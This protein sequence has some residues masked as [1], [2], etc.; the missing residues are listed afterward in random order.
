MPYWHDWDG[1]LP[2]QAI[3]PL[4][5]FLIFLALGIN[6]TWRRNGLTGITPLAMG[7]AYICF[8]AIFRNSGGR[9]ILPID[10]ISVLYYSVGLAFVSI[11]F[12]G[13]I[14]NRKVPQSFPAQ[15]G[16]S[17]PPNGSENLL[18]SYKF[19]GIILGFLLLGIAVPL[20]E[21]S[22]QQLY[23]E[24]R[25][26]E[27]LAELMD[28]QLLPEPMRMSLETFLSQ[29]GVAIAGRS[30]YPRF[31]PGATEDFTKK[32]QDLKPAPYHRLSF[33]IAGPTSANMV[34]PIAKKPLEFPNASNILVFACPD[35]KVLAV[36]LFNDSGSPKGIL[37]RSPFP[38]TL[39]CPLPEIVN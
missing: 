20:V 25:K 30:L 35:E 10:W 39:S 18:H 23:P 8:N 28:T 22:F 37:A 31:I 29:G 36:V 2:N 38:A 9:Y 16:R 27:M 1:W 15:Q 21:N 34:I 4:F 19:Y 13:F 32:D 3:V 12:L 7:F 33:Y 6:E 26:N 17:Q 11:T 14:L 24:T 5:V